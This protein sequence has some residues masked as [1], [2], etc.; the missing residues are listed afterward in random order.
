MLNLAS[1]VETNARLYPRHTAL[2]TDSETIT[3]QKLNAISN[4]VANGLSALGVL[5]GDKVALS[6][7]TNEYFP[8]CYYGI[9]KAGAVV[10]SLNPLLKRDEIARNLEDSDAIVYICDDGGGYLSMAEEGYA[11][12]KSVQSCQT[13]CLIPTGG[14]FELSDADTLLWEG[15]IAA[16]SVSFDMVQTEGDAPCS[17]IFTSGTTGRAKGAELTHANC[18]LA[19]YAFR[20]V[21]GYTRDDVVLVSAPMFSGLGQILLMG[22]TFTVGATLVLQQRFDP[23]TVF[24]VMERYCVSVFVGVPTMYFA[25]LHYLRLHPRNLEGLRRHWHKGAVGGAPVPPSLVDD[26]EEVFGLRL[27][28]GYG[29]SETTS[30]L[31]F[32]RH[33][34]PCDPESVGVPIWGME[35]R[36]VDEQMNDVPVGEAGEIV[37]RGPMVMRGY[38]KRPEANAEAFRGGWFHTGDVGKLDKDGNLYILDRIK[39]MIIRGGFN[40]YPCQ[41]EA[42]LMSHPDIQIAAVIGMPDSRVGEEICAYV[43]LREGV[44]LTAKEIITWSKERIAAHAYPR[45]I[46]F[47]GR[48]PLGSTNKVLKSELRRLASSASACDEKR[49]NC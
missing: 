28:K 37:A 44:K 38:Y 21:V 32:T 9:L 1:I 48:M 29:L 16:Q 40:V 25:L 43:Q 24:M 49:S 36:V 30:V 19:G 33:G 27:L 18:V 12:F 34:R 8:F 46:E 6:C 4:Q 11:A 23:E 2:I 22:G 5:P 35:I 10:V 15:L 7:L 39:D 3:Y 17:I 26:V 31:A 42:V 45:Q 13:F 41:V 14:D 47:I 20:D